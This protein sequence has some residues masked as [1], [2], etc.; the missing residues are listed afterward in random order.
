MRHLRRQSRT[1]C[2]W[3]KP[4]HPHLRVW[5]QPRS[6]GVGETTFHIR[7]NPPPALSHSWMRTCVPRLWRGTYAWQEGR[8]APKKVMKRVVKGGICLLVPVSTSVMLSSET[9]CA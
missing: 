1:D 4:F 5:P 2:R 7:P 6:C 8:S 9:V 3:K